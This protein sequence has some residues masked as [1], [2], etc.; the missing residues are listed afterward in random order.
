MRPT[1]DVGDVAV[2][3][4][5]NPSK[6]TFG[7]VIQYWTEE[8]MI[9]H[10]VTDVFQSGGVYYFTTK[11]DANSIQDDPISQDQVIGKVI[12]TIPKIGWASI[13]IKMIIYNIWS[14]FSSQI[15][16]GYA[17]VSISLLLI[18]VFIRSKI[19]KP[20]KVWHRSVL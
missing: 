6:I 9:I 11:G 8:S 16:L 19:K 4:E 14:F 15:Y 3:L 17:I 12:L 7:N 1:L 13:Y 18:M 5:S 10:R 20:K 2:V